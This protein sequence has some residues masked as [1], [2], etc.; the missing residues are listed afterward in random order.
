MAGAHPCRAQLHQPVFAVLRVQAEREPDGGG[1]RHHTEADAEPL[2]RACHV[3]DDKEDEGGKQPACEDEQVLRLQS[4]ELH[5]TAYALVDRVFSHCPYT[6]LYM[7]GNVR[8]LKEERTENRCAHNQED[9]RPEPACCGLRG[10]GVAGAELAIY[11]DAPDKPDDSADGVDTFVAGSKYE[12]TMLVAS[13][14]P[15]MPL[16]CADAEMFAASRRAARMI[17][18]FFNVFVI[19]VSFLCL[20]V[21]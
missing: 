2:A 3:Q 13:V 10:V 21:G 18:F 6:L 17:C 8:L 14:M 7:Y 20:R 19:I 4:L 1:S 9:A 15:A 16:P 11:L 12:V 5:R